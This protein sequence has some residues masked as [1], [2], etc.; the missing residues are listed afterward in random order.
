MLKKNLLMSSSYSFVDHTADI[1]V[2]IKADSLEE[3]FIASVQAFKE[4][5]VEPDSLTSKEKYIIKLDSH[6]PESLLVNFLNEL[7]YRLTYKNKIVNNIINMKIAQTD[8]NWNLVCTLEE[9]DIDEDKIK[10]EIKSVTYHQMEI[11]ED[12]GK[13]STRIVFDI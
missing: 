1:A 8:G 3:L 9:S 2:D 5:V 7:N 10:T 12:K 13:Y 11:K 6:S 4:V